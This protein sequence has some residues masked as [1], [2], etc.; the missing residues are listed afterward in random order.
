MSLVRLRRTQ[1]GDDGARRA[2][3]DLYSW[4][5]EGFTTAD[6]VAAKALLT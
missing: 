1:G 4:F 3:A 5:T 2:L 6:L